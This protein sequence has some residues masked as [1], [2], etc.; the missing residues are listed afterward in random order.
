MASKKIS[1]S[2]EDSDLAWLKRRAKRTHGGN[3]SAVL[4]EATQLLP[5]QEALREFPDAEKVPMLSTEEVAAIQAEWQPAPDE[6]RSVPRRD[7][8]RHRRTDR[9]RTAAFIVGSAPSA[10]YG[11]FAGRR[12]TPLQQ[13]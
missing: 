1:V 10:C 4:A 8:V 3:V 11:Q 7:H 2:M 9:H 5:R 6:R 13:I 12:Q